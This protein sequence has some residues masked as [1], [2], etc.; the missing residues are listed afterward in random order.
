MRPSFSNSDLPSRS[1]SRRI[2]META[3]CVRNTCPAARVKLPVSAMATK[4]LELVE[5]EG[6][7]HERPSIIKIDGKI[8]RN[9]RS[10]NQCGNEKRSS[11]AAAHTP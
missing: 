5:V 8:K 11:S 2:C 4:G 3:D 1:S 6:R 10:T 9:I 7:G